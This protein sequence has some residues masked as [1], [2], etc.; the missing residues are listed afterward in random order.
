MIREAID[1]LAE[2]GPLPDESQ[3]IADCILEAYDEL[4]S[5]ITPPLSIE[6]AER[7]VVLFPPTACFGIEWTLLHLIESTPNWPIKSIIDLCPSPEWREQMLK[8][9]R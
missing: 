1:K 2:L 8:R 5:A 6:E 7:L 3:D 9:I 4:F